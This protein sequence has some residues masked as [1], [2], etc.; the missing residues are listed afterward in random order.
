MAAKKSKD[1]KR[2]SKASK[3]EQKKRLYSKARR[4]GAVQLNKIKSAGKAAPKAKR[5]QLRKKQQKKQHT[6]KAAEQQNSSRPK[7]KKARSSA[8]KRPYAKKGL[9][10]QAIKEDN[11]LDFEE[12]DIGAVES[13]AKEDKILAAEAMGLKIESN[14]KKTS[15]PLFVFFLVL[16]FVMLMLAYAF[17][18]L[19]SSENRIIQQWGHQQDVISEKI[20]GIFAKEK[21]EK[22]EH[23]APPKDNLSNKSVSGRGHKAIADASEAEQDTEKEMANDSAENAIICGD[24]ICNWRELDSCPA[25]CSKR[26][27]PSTEKPECGDNV[28]TADEIKT[29]P[30]DCG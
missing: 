6:K 30:A 27:I 24:G 1:T 22:L 10:E 8:V 23:P 15:Y 14:A 29:C 16:G 18:P 5:R 28:C 7:Q 13:I 17:I 25:D 2:H 12:I 9:V 4:G 3:A 21:Q 19:P 26:N 20:S 11:N